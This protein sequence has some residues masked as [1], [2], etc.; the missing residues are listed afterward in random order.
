MK[1]IGK[2]LVGKILRWIAEIAG[3]KFQKQEVRSEKKEYRFQFRQWTSRRGPGETCGQMNNAMVVLRM[4]SAIGFTQSSGRRNE[5]K[6]RCPFRCRKAATA[7][8]IEKPIR[9]KNHGCE[10]FKV[11]EEGKKTDPSTKAEASKR[12]ECQFSF[13]GFRVKDK[14]ARQSFSQRWS[15]NVLTQSEPTSRNYAPTDLPGRTKSGYLSGGAQ[16]RPCGKP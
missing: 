3:S 4:T 7:A 8:W 12:K 9:S 13:S 16:H 15:I 6:L 1:R 11:I 5:P 14:A 10:S 2:R